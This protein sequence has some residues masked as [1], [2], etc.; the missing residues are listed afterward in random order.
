MEIKIKLTVESRSYEQS[1]LSRD[2]KISNAEGQSK[3]LREGKRHAALTTSPLTTLLTVLREERN[4]QIKLFGSF[5]K[6]TAGTKP[7]SQ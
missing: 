1:Y 5:P 6:T 7:P 3:I 4:L 2:D